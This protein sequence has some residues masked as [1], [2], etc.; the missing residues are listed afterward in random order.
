MCDRNIHEHTR[1]NKFFKPFLIIRIIRNEMP[2]AA[3]MAQLEGKKHEKGQKQKNQTQRALRWLGSRLEFI[4]TAI[5]CVTSLLAVIQKVTQG[6]DGI[7]VSALGLA[8]VYSIAMTQ[9]L[10]GMTRSLGEIEANM[11]SVE[12]VMASCVDVPRRTI[13]GHRDSPSNDRRTGQDSK[14]GISGKDDREHNR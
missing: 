12:R 10:G 13:H 2:P 5:V 8:I 7:N 11:N 4:G 9:N 3:A 1:V 14:R 6:E